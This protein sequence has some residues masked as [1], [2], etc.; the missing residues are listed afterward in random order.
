MSFEYRLSILSNIDRVS[1]DNPVESIDR[2]YRFDTRPRMPLE[3]M[4]RHFFMH[5]ELPSAQRK[6]RRLKK[7]NCIWN[8]IFKQGFQPV[9]TGT[10]GECLYLRV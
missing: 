3:D 6:G 1:I 5:R 2:G 10:K 4:N 8:N 9:I 7:V